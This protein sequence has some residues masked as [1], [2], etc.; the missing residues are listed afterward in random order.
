MC[1]KDLF[2][3]CPHDGQQ[4]AEK[5]QKPRKI[6]VSKEIIS[7]R[8]KGMRLGY[9]TFP[10]RHRHDVSHQQWRGGDCQNQQRNAQRLRNADVE[11]DN[12]EIIIF[13]TP[14][15]FSINDTE[16]LTIEYRHENASR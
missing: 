5:F 13:M 4:Q 16:S 12:Q 2:D 7:R 15:E 8:Q 14:F 1:D 6:D 9:E 11:Y 3:F 10:L